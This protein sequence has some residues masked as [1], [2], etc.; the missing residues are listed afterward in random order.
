L[1]SEIPLFDET[2]VLFLD[3]A[4][5]LTGRLRDAA[6]LSEVAARARRVVEGPLSLRTMVESYE[7]LYREA[8]GK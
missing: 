4:P 5:R 8:T 1:A 6:G 3:D 2:N 7:K